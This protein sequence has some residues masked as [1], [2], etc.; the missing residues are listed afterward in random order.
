MQLTTINSFGFNGENYNKYS[1]KQNQYDDK[2]MNRELH[3][4]E[5]PNCYKYR[6]KVDENEVSQPQNNQISE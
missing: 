5:V 3:E 6:H 1:S 2:D 4:D